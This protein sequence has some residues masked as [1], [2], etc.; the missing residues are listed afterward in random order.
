MQITEIHIPP[1]TRFEYYLITGTEFD[2]FEYGI[3]SDRELNE[4][5]LRLRFADDEHTIKV[6]RT[7]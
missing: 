5:D 2:T 3:T 6:H 1:Y 4:F 7:K